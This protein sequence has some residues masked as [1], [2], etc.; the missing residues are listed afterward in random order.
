MMRFANKN[1]LQILFV[2]TCIACEANAEES[3]VIDSNMLNEQ[4]VSEPG[5]SV[6]APGSISPEASR[7]S[8]S[9]GT[10]E[11]E[12]IFERLH[13]GGKM[14]VR[15]KAALAKAEAAVSNKQEAEDF[16]AT[17]LS[18]RGVISLPNGL[19]YLIRKPGRGKKPKD[20]DIILCRYT[21]K[22]IDGTDFDYTAGNAPVPLAVSGFIPGMR[23]A[24]KLMAVGSKWQVVV[25][26]HLAYGE[27]GD[28]GIGPNAV[29]IYEIEISSIK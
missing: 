15:Q 16:L 6:P 24:I 1:I 14:S 7:S 27:K 26:P 18:T 20:S 9:I 2:I 21:G 3:V 25:P 23:E 22:L 19:Q 12:V 29:L 13:R 10:P 11:S 28:R 17:N 5:S 4:S 8:D